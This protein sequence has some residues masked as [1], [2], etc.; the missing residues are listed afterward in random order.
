VLLPKLALSR[1]ADVVN[2]IGEALVATHVDRRRR[3]EVAAGAGAPLD[4]VR[5]WRQRFQAKAE[6]IRIQFTELAHE[7]DP[8]L[9]GVPTRGSPEQDALEAIGMAAAA[10]VRRFGPQPLWHLVAAASDGR[11]LSNTSSPLLM[12][13]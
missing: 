13:P 10:A 5:G 8:E 4:T 11:L 12:P 2:V 3:R 9:A 7:W 1:R 6:E